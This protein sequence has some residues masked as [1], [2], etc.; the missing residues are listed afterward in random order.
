MTDRRTLLQAVAALGAS[1]LAPG[2]H[3]QQLDAA[4]FGKLSA[5]LTGYPAADPAT[6][7][8][9]MRAFATPQ[10]RASLRAL[11]TLA[12][13]TPPDRLDAAIAAAKLDKVANDLCA[14]WYSGMVDG[15][16]VLY[17]DAL[18]WTVMTYSKPMGI[19]GGVTGYWAEP[20][21]PT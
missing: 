9:V 20:W 13:S 8:K 1:A 19:C 12:A 21:T 18:V 2:L 7:A 16:V 17:T 6:V 5:A 14:A 4:A 15:K 11:T 10:R 3:A